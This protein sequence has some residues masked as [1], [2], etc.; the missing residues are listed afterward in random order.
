MKILYIANIRIPSERV[1]SLQVMKMCEALANSGL[2]TELVI[3]DRRDNLGERDIREFYGVKNNF[4]IR[5]IAN[6]DLLGVSTKFSKLFYW[7][8]FIFFFFR[9]FNIKVR[10]DTI[11]YSRDPI[12]TWPFV[13]K[14]KKT[15][16]E[17]HDLPK[18]LDILKRADRI[19]TITNNLKTLLVQMGIGENKIIVAPDAV[20]MEKFDIDKTK[21]EARSSL[22]LDQNEKLVIYAGSRQIWKGVDTLYKASKLIK[23]ARVLMITDKSYTQVPLYLKAA[24]ILV[25]PNSAKFN[26][27]RLYTSPMKLFEYMAAKRPIVA[28]DLPSIREILDERTAKF[29]IPDDPAS[30]AQAIEH[31]L[32]HPDEGEKIAKEAYERSKG[33]TWENRARTIIESI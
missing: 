15:I 9:L 20:D 17:I 21:S 29:F 1:H 11:V 33:Y 18:G 22:N 27:S 2:E 31:L 12:L 19:V 4:V 25:L 6:P 30:L 23:G 16:V 3:P 32:A 26:I 13:R 14:G 5:R 10:E 7:I 24:D 28:S 8:D